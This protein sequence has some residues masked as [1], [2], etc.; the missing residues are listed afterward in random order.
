VSLTLG[1]SDKNCSAAEKINEDE[2][3]GS[4][5]FVGSKGAMSAGR[6]GRIP[7]LTKVLERKATNR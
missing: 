5:K 6:D 7:A 4:E 2:Y 3:G 1:S